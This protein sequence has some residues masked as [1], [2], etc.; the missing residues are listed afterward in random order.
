M[1]N[2]VAF[3]L[4]VF[5]AVQ[6]AQAKAPEKVIYSFPGGG[7]GVTTVGTLTPDQQGNLYGVVAGTGTANGAVFELTLSSAGRW[8]ETNIYSFTGGSDGSN[9]SGGVIFDQAG[10]L[11]GVTTNGGDGC[12]GGCGTVFEL[13]RGENGDWTETVLYS[14]TGSTDGG[15]PAGILVFD[16]AGNLYGG[17]ETGGDLSCELSGKLGCG[18]VF[19]LSPGKNGQWTEKV[20]HSFK[21]HKDGVQEVPSGLVFDGAGN[22]YGTTALGGK[23]NMG[24]VFEL[25]PR[26]GGAWTETILH[27]F[28]GSPDGRTP[29]SSLAFSGGFLYGTTAYGGN[30]TC[31]EGVGCGTVFQL[32][33]NGGEWTETIILNLQGSDG[34][35]PNGPPLFDQ[36]GNLYGTTSLGGKDP[37]NNCGTAFELAPDGN[38]NWQES[39]LHNFGSRTGDAISPVSGLIFG[40]SGMLFGTSW[41]GGKRA[42]GTVYE[43]TP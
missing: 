21:G 1:K 8:K 34:I 20:I 26:R 22:L 40:Q 13:T 11:Y 35:G 39:I 31:L 10:N 17:T 4:L 41:Q 42:T 19:E 2:N 29:A 6:L 25:S 28:Q 12:S 30:S 3:L 38:G 16:Q 24:I 5:A 33:E 9:P 15:Y 37:C 43:I 27:T 32:A 36:A 7:T 14:F 23:G 18:T